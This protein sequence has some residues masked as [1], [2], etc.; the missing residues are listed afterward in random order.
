MVSLRDNKFG[1]VGK[2]VQVLL[3]VYYI[4]FIM[5]HNV[6]DVRMGIIYKIIHACYSKYPPIKLIQ[7]NKT[8]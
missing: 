2:L 7:H 8:I 3:T 5:I 6:L 4:L 1:N